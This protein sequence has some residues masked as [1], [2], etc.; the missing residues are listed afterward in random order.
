MKSES[1]ERGESCCTIF[2]RTSLLIDIKISC[3]G[4]FLAQISC[5]FVA[6]DVDKSLN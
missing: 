5:D 1:K 3:K 2:P 6:G 4:G